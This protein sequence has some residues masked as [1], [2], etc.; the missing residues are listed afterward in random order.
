M[1]SNVALTA[2]LLVAPKLEQSLRAGRA[3]R[4]GIAGVATRAGIKSKQQF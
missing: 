3:R 1:S 2:L 4:F